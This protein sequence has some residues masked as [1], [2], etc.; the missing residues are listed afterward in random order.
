MFVDVLEV[1]LGEFALAL[2]SPSFFNIYGTLYA[3]DNPQRMKLAQ[4]PEKFAK[5]KHGF[6]VLLPCRNEEAVIGE[7]IYKLSQANYPKSRFELL[8]ICTPDDPGTIAAAKASIKEHKIRNAKVIVFDLPAG[9]SR[10][11][12]IGLSQA[13]HD[14]VTIFDSE[15]DVSP[16][17]FNIANTLYIQREIDVLQCGVQLMDYNNRWYSAHNVLEYFF[18]FKSRMH[19]HAKMGIVPL[20]GNT[21]FFK[22]TDLK[23][24]GGWDEQGLTEDADLGI[25]LSL[26][27]KK[28]DVMYDPAHVTKEETPPSAKIFIKQRTRWNQGF[29][30]ILGKKD[31]KRLATWKQRALILY[32]LCAPTFMSF[33]ILFSPAL[34]AIGFM[35]KVSVIV[36]LLTFIPLFLSLLTILISLIGLYEFGKD[37][38][39]KVKWRSYAWLIITFLPYQVILTISAARAF[40]RERTGSRGWEKTAHV[41]AHRVKQVKEP[42]PAVS[43]VSVK[44]ASSEEAA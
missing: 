35:F 4:A 20:G 36:S 12:N 18:W 22:A 43:A 33:V 28:F 39:I 16:D 26:M 10:G 14:L 23:E 41:G 42:A 34:V 15:D 44:T 7:T 38:G 2:I 25:R 30:Q 40:V 24:V 8:V 32:V 6:T 27:G 31:W 5:P 1:L 13:K 21:V 11:M 9:K 19:F 3:W 29:L 17:I 37:Q